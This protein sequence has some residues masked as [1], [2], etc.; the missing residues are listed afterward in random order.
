MKKITDL[1]QIKALYKEG[2]ISK[3]SYYRGI[4]RGWVCVDY[5]KPH[6]Q[7]KKLSSAELDR[8][9]RYVFKVV[10]ILFNIYKKDS[11]AEPILQDIIDDVYLYILE[12]GYTLEDLR[13]I[14]IEYIIKSLY[15]Q[16]PFWAKYLFVP[17]SK[18]HRSS[19][20][21]EMLKDFNEIP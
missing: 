6:T 15:L 21:R 14:K 10:A 18:Y 19:E 20:D 2:K 13:K 8:M 3:A 7:P 17:V 11:S 9:Y 4:K 12:R 5:H 1:N 16:R